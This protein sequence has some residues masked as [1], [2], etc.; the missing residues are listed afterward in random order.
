MERILFGDNQF[1]GVNHMSEEKARAQALMFRETRD[2]IRVLDAAYDAGVRVFMC[3]THDRV[4]EVADVVRANPERYPDFQFYPCMPYAHKYANS[5]GEVGILETV[6]RF[7][8]GGVLE[9]IVKGAVSAVTQ[10][11]VK[12]MQILVDA[13]MKRFA[14]TRTPIVF[15]QN[16][17]TDLLL[18][19]RLEHLLAAF[20]A[21]VRARY[22]AE[23][24]FITMNLPL[25]VERLERAGVKDPIVC[26]NI[27][28]IGFRMSGG[29]E[30]YREVL[31]GGRCRAIAMSVFASGAIPPREAIE[32]VC[33][34]EGVQSIVFGASS[35][36]HIRDTKALIDEAWG[37]RRD[38]AALAAV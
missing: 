5:V 27:N 24:G 17:V 11:A 10:D 2:I 3:T 16:V 25:L 4:G 29:V 6:R 8:P 22:G 23:A 32:W 38:A 14:G 13:E 15:V 36:R 12:L 20:A 31:R 21:H 34:L 35:A 26:A 37:L 9:T 7:A 1:F 33:R 30:A 19:L 28:K 18:G